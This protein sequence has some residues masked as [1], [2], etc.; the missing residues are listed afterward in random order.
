MYKQRNVLFYIGNLLLKLHDL[1]TS[2]LFD[3]FRNLIRH[4]CCRCI[5]FR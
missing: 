3:F 1:V 4:R 5:F 2:G